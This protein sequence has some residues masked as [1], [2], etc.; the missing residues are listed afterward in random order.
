[1]ADASLPGSNILAA[2]MVT[3]AVRYDLVLDLNF[4]QQFYRSLD[5]LPPRIPLQT[6][7]QPERHGFL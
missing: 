5:P 4:P 2:N 7:A 3:Q 1:M 6:A